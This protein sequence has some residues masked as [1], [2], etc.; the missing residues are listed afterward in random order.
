MKADRRSYLKQL[1]LSC[2]VVVALSEENHAVGAEMAGVITGIDGVKLFSE[3]P[4][5]LRMLATNSIGVDQWNEGILLQPETTTNTFIIAFKIL[6]DAESA[7]KEFRKLT[8]MES[9]GGGNL[10]PPKL[11]DQ[12]V[13]F[14]PSRIMI[15]RANVLITAFPKDGDANAYRQVEAFIKF[16][17]EKIRVRGAGVMTQTPS[18]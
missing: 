11:G 8:V 5:N 10:I 9:T 7:A 18:P 2:F 17:D 6:P 4:A 14:G 13:M 12:V 16:I 15:R 1:T 3:Y